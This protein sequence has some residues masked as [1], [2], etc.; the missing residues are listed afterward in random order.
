M[1]N[2]KI[3]TNKIQLIRFDKLL[4]PCQNVCRLSC[5]SHIFTDEYT[6]WHVEEEGTMFFLGYIKCDPNSVFCSK[7]FK[8]KVFNSWQFGGAEPQQMAQHKAYQ[9][10]EW[11]FE[12]EMKNKSFLVDLFTK[13]AIE[14]CDVQNLVL[15]WKDGADDLICYPILTDYK[16]TR[17]AALGAYFADHFL[18]L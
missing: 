2:L 6:I 5:R 12:N 4:V 16:K 1:Q 8:T 14:L 9:I 13:F 17:T 15:L 7:F 18:T 10:I 11:E 3:D